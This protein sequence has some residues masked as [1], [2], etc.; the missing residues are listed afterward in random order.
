MSENPIQ[1][2]SEKLE[3]FKTIIESDLKKTTEELARFQNDQKDQKQHLANTNVDFNQSS[4]HFQQQAKDKQLIRRL[5]DK[6]RELQAALT[7]IENKT[8]GICDRTGQLI[9]EE[10]LLA[11][12]TARFD[13]LPN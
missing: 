6:S 9:R 4:K 13:I 2:S 3:K 8:Y 5:Q 7:R 10:R 11:K 12:S 1:Y